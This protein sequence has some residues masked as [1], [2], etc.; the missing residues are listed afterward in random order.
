MTNKFIPMKTL[1]PLLAALTLCITPI[2]ASA[3]IITE[4]VSGHI[5]TI[6]NPVGVSSQL[7]SLFKLGDSFTASFT[8]DSSSIGIDMTPYCGTPTCSFYQLYNNMQQTKLNY[9]T[10]DANTYSTTIDNNNGQIGYNNYTINFF[11][12]SGASTG[13][14]TPYHAT[15]SVNSPTASPFSPKSEVE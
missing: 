5:S 13:S 4:T 15:F 10:V 1:H 12:L 8:Y 3:T 2:V 11:G 7:S 9:F 6:T 14:L